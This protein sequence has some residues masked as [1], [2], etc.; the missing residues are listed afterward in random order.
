MNRNVWRLEQYYYC[1]AWAKRWLQE[2]EVDVGALVN[3]MESVLRKV[4]ECLQ[5]TIKV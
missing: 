3:I 2:A 4:A 5:I 1:E